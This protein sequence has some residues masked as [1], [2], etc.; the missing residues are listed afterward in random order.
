MPDPIADRHLD[1]LLAFNEAVPD[2]EFVLQV[3]Q[4]LRK[5]QRRRRLI[6]TVCGLVGAAFGAVGAMLLSQPIARIF[7]DLPPT[8]TMQAVLVGVAAM[9]F[10]AWMMNEDVRLDT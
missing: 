4:R 8:A 9:A 10:Y 5:E 3:M 7:T 2:D 6:L 1:E